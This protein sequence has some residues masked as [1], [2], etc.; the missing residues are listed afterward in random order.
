MGLNW[1]H[2][3]FQ[4]NCLVLSALKLATGIL[5]KNGVFVT[6]IFRSNDYQSLVDVFEKLFKKVCYSL[7]CFIDVLKS[8]VNE[9]FRFMFG[10]LQHLD[11][12]QL[13]YSLCAKSI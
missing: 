12:N 4:Q 11:W 5:A 13:K 8:I 6:K 10:N 2:D 1:V 7:S 9:G 3:A